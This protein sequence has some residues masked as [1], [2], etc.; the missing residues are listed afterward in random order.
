M[1]ARRVGQVLSYRL[2]LPDEAQ[3]EA[4][5]LL[6]VS[7]A[8]VNQTLTELWS[9]LDAFAAARIGPA[10]KQVRQYT[11]SPDPHGDRQWRCESETAGRILHAQ[12]SRKRAFTL[13]QPILTDGFIHPKNER[14]PAGKHLRA[15]KDALSALKQVQRDE[16][17]GQEGDE[18]TFVALQNVVEQACNFF[19]EYER[20]PANYEEMQPIPFL[21]VGLLTYAGDDGTDKGQAYRLRLDINGVDDQGAGMVYFRFRCPDTEARWSWRVGETRI[22]LPQVAQAHLRE[23]ELLAPTLREVRRATGERYAVLDLSLAVPVTEPVVW[24]SLERIVGADWG[25]HTLLTATAIDT[26][27]QQVGRPFFLNTGGCD[28]RQARTHRQ[29][30]ELKAKKKQ[31]EQARDALPQEQDHP[32]RVWYMERI[33]VYE[34]QIALCWRKYDLR[35][36]TLAHLDANVLLL[37]CHLHG[38]SL[39]AME[40]LK[41]LKTT[42]RG[43]GVRG[44]WWNYRNNTTIRGEIWRL[45]RDKRRLA[46]LRFHTVAPRG[47]S[48]TCPWCGASAQ[49]YRSPR[50][51]QRGE[52]AVEWGRWLWCA[53]CHYNG[54]RDRRGL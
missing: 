42:G 53:A 9:H 4:L 10:W 48:H 23:G 3:A 22:P 31:F 41:T 17:S 16:Q 47:T 33:A 18:T 44:R 21:K 54:D 46:G 39:L 25:V 45:L 1:R 34:R 2:R 7:R 24:E 11:G 52:A 12:A 15:I 38:S 6:D 20:F 49:T 32:R 27:G 26:H 37:L 13:I 43:R 29:I 8:V 35:N 36:R 30:D 28:G 19:L 14:K 51:R 40:S 5:R 50:A